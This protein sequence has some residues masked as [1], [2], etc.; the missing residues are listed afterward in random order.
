MT[1]KGILYRPVMS[2]SITILLLGL[3]ACDS[4]LIITS[5]FMFGLPGILN[6]QAFMFTIITITTTI[7]DLSSL[8][9]A[10]SGGE[11]AI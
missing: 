10:L 3:S 9:G 5:L 7:T 4:L 11:S 1:M 2:S 8:L 6:H